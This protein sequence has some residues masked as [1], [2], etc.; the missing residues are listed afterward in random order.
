MG[1]IS[2][3]TRAA[4]V[5]AAAA[6]AA[7]VGTA[8]A[9]AYK[10]N[11]QLEVKATGFVNGVSVS[12][13]ATSA[14]DDA[15][16]G[17]HFDRSYFELRYHPDANT[18]IRTTLDQKASDGTVFVKYL[19]WQEK[20]SDAFAIKIGQ[21][22]TPIIDYYENDVWGY[23]YV[24]KTFLDDVG[25][26]TSSDIGVSA[27]GKGGDMV[28]YYVSITN[29]EG[30]THT[31]DGAGFAFQGRLEAHAAGAHVGVFGHSETKHNGVDQ[32]NPTREDVYTYYKAPQFL[33]AAQ[34]LMAD[35]GNAATSFDSGKGWSA[36]ARAM[37]PFGQKTEAFARYDTIDAKDTGTDTTLTIVGVQFQAAPGVLIAPN[38]QIRDDGT[39][40]VTTAGVHAQ[41][42]I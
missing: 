33:V 22:Q 27:Y 39:D 41:F 6:A 28:D 31:P 21:N 13:N 29:G 9:F 14:A 34:Y 23:R 11:D 26:E 36:L 24:A 19:Y 17:F 8:P 32:Y 18:M 35:D 5:L 40:T 37:L 1:R 30:Y 25:A 4:V 42:A 3:K 20:Y 12:G 38:V 10:V 2:W 15:A 7:L 16:T